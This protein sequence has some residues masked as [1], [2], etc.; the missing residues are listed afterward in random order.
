ML[1]KLLLIAIFFANTSYAQTRFCEVLRTPD[2]AT[3]QLNSAENR[4]DFTNHGGLLNGGVCWWHSRFTRNALY[5]AMFKPQI[6]AGNE[7]TT[8]KLIKAIRKG[9]EVVIIN[10]YKNLREFSRLNAKLIQKELESWQRYDGLLRQQWT[11]GLWGWH[12]LP[13]QKL[14]A[15]VG[16]LYDYVKGQGNIAYLKLQIKGI[17]AHS[18][19]VTDMK[20]NVDGYT[21]KIIDSNFLHTISYR[22]YYGDRSFNT[23]SYGDFIPYLGK[24]KEN[25]QNKEIRSSYCQI[26]Q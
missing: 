18:W 13:A 21:L 24:R 3:Q 6:P 9:K 7:E 17:T 2:F 12:R 5:K 1:K 22:Y 4:L 16:N 20:K 10:G 11:V 8:K 23:R 15:R 19:L 26:N 25:I 14:R